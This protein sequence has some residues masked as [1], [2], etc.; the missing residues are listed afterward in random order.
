MNANQSPYEWVRDLAAR[1]CDGLLSREE[2]AAFETRLHADPKALEHFVLYMELHAQIAW[3][4]RAEVEDGQRETPSRELPKKEPVGSFPPSASATTPGPIILDLA[5]VANSPGGLF[6]SGT[7]LSYTVSA[8][9][10][11]LG[12][13][14]GWISYLPNAPGVAQ[15][16]QLPA[17]KN[18]EP[19]MNFVARVTGLEDCQFVAGSETAERSFVPIGRQYVLQSGLLEITYDSGAKV[20]LQGP[21]RFE[22]DSAM[23]GFLTSGKLTA[24]IEK[25]PPA[26]PVTSPS[27]ATV[28][29]PAPL[30]TV[31]TPTAVVTDLGTEFGVAVDELGQT[32]A[33]VFQGQVKVVPLGNHRGPAWGTVVNAGQAVRCVANRPLAVSSAGD[34][35]SNFVR[36][37]RR[38]P[39]EIPPVLETFQGPALGSAFEQF[40]SGRFAISNGAAV[41]QQPPL[42]PGA[43]YRG[44]IRTVATDFCYRDFVF[45]ATFHVHLDNPDPALRPH[46]HYVFFGIG[47]GVPNPDFFDEVSRGLV[48]A[49][50]VDNGYAFVR[51]CHPGATLDNTTTPVAEVIAPG[52]LKP[53]GS[54]RFRM[55]KTGKKVR[56]AI[57]SAIEGPFR[58]QFTSHPMNLREFA[59]LLNIGNSRLLVGTGNCDTMTVRFEELSIRFPK[60]N[61]TDKSPATNPPGERRRP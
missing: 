6:T 53:S 46:G 7:L 42:A 27:D 55:T 8:A 4:V 34:L 14:L 43:Q 50:C 11:L 36:T 16:S 38:K 59:P 39:N 35:A 32:E 20:I 3:N 23:G 54:Y 19:E 31:Q 48:L 29:E 1:Y 24:Q 15:Q 30:F 47:D 51:R 40:P 37:L 60:N 56:F 57:D 52:T 28:A 49:Y 17:T 61:E 12:L 13:W 45:E 33:R 9:V 41:F 5:P 26:K 44:Y 58:E 2:T 10:V 25:K 18:V 22:V 21:A